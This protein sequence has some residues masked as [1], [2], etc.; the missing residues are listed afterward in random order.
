MVLHVH[1]N[2]LSSLQ[3]HQR[4]HGEFHIRNFVVVNGGD[5]K[6]ITSDEN[7]LGNVVIL[8]VLIRATTLSFTSESKT[9]KPPL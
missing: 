4:R 5:G 9:E 7:K 2:R 1:T 3:M 6:L 8:H